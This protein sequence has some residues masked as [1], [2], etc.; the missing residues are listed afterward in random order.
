MDERRKITERE[1]ETR[2]HGDDDDITLHPLNP[3]LGTHIWRGEN[4][5]G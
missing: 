1:R 2:I 4:K 3:V 5:T